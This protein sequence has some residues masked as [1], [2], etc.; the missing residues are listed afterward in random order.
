MIKRILKIIGLLLLIPILYVG[1]TLIHGTVTDFQ[2]EESISLEVEQA[3]PPKVIADSSLTFM[4]WNVGYGGLGE[5][6]D[7]FYDNG[8]FLTSAGKTVRTTQENVEKNIQGAVNFIKNKRADFYL[9]QEVDFDSKRSYYI[10]QFEQYE[11][12]LPNYASTFSV[13]YR[14]PRVP[15]P[16]FEPW[17]VMG[18]MESGLG[19]FS[20]Y[21]PSQATRYQLPGD[22]PWPDRI[23]HLDRCAA[24][25]RYPTADGKEL[26]VVNIH[27]SAYDK[28]GTLKKQQMDYLKSKFEEEYKKG[29]YLVIG[30][31]WNQRPTGVQAA[32]FGG[33]I[34]T[35]TTGYVIPDDY[36]RDWKWA[37]DDDTPTNRS[38]KDPYNKGV[39]KV[40]LIDFFLVSPNLEIVEVEGVNL[41]FKYS[42]HQPVMLTVAFKQES[43]LL[44]PIDNIEV[45]SVDSDSN[46]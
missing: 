9:F 18:K 35:E 25:H 14:A 4:I 30:G 6:S 26:I 37:Y 29:N 33:E 45:E 23:F 27:N 12:A 42:D 39:S 10:N 11:E 1:I 36:F 34:L 15:L 22:Y 20:K 46:Q 2:P 40:N 21:Q 8:G 24:F 7:F 38:L 13:N 5:E 3:P 31:D 19:T 16:V 28:G 17:N 44:T 43:N 41:D 32:S